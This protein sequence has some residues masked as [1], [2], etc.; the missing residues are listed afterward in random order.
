MYPAIWSAKWPT[1]LHVNDVG[2]H[3]VSYEGS[4]FRGQ[5]PSISDYEDEDDDEDDLN[6]TELLISKHETR[7]AYPAPRNA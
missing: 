3:E 6:K 5:G 1:L 7:T 2:F 4:R